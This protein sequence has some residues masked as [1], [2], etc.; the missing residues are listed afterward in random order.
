M[1]EKQSMAQPKQSMALKQSMSQQKQSMAQQKQSMAQKST[2][3]VFTSVRTEDNQTK[4]TLAPIHVSY[5]N[6]LRRIILTGVESI[7]FR[8]D[9]TSTG[10]TS[11]VLVKQNDTPMTNEMLADRIGLLPIY[12]DKPLQW[13]KDTYVFTL[14]VTGSKD[15]T[16]YVKSKDFTI[17]ETRTIAFGEEVKGDE[18]A[19]TEERTI[20]STEFFHPNPITGDTPLIAILQPSDPEQKIHIIAKASIG[21]G[22]EHARFSTVSQ[23]S[24]EYT[25]DDDPQRIEE[26]F[27]TWLAVSK[28][29]GSIDKASEQYARMQ[30][31]FN[32]MQIKRCYL[33]NEKQQPYSFD[34]TIESAGPLDVQYIVKRAC[35]V[36]ENMCNAFV[37]IEKGELPKEITISPADTRIIGFDFLIRGHD[38]T[39]GNLLQTWLVEHHIEGMLEPRIAYAG[40]SVPHPLR[41]EII[42][43]IGVP[44]GDMNI[45]KR[46]VANAAR[47]CATMFKELRLSWESS[48]GGP[49]QRRVIRASKPGMIDAASAPITITKI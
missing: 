8:S 26:M 46:A 25:L 33:I 16:T 21:T 10:T 28:K 27:T 9:M 30:R 19:T 48:Q 14:D 31:E 23:C 35:E 2:D 15:Q 7:A 45:A 13:N 12:V 22:R 37:N 29:I 17:K 1:A 40:Y 39:L 11:D 36:A 3:A 42:L 49:V 44:D 32:T 47:G 6:T 24:Y 18:D 5:A 38:H 20:S 4:F 41:D 34:F 43:R